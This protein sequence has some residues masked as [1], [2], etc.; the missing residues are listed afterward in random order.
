MGRKIFAFCLAVLL[1]LCCPTAAFAEAFEPDRTGA[2]SVTLLDQ[3]DKTPIVG[4]E[5]SVYYVATVS[6]NSNGNLSYAHT[7]AFEES[8]LELNDPALAAKLDALVSRN[9]VPA[10]K[11]LTD[12]AGSAICEELPL[13]LY[14][15]KQTGAVEGYAPCTSFLVTVP[16]RNADGY[17]YRVNASPKTDIVRLASITVKKVWDTDA[18]TPIADSVTVQLLRDGQ[19]VQTAILSEQNDWQITYPDMPESDS[20]SVEEVNIPKGFIAVYTQKDYVFTVINMAS[21]PHTGQLT[22][23]IPLLSMLGLLLLAA[24]FLLLRKKEVSK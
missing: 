11:M 21:L 15:V 9:P 18:S 24:G 13:G 16:V 8:G 1:M 20:Y 19:V 6:V 14:F 17:E 10:A 22:W 7:D 4:A 2:I 5:L 3:R 12:E 23:P